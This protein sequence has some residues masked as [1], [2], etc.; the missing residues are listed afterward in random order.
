METTNA[1][2][3]TLLSLFTSSRPSRVLVFHLIF[4]YKLARGFYDKHTHKFSPS[5]MNVL[6]YFGASSIYGSLA[7]FMGVFIRK[8][9]FQPL[10]K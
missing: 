5:C 4:I 2:H 7:E 10:N 1:L 8:A 3:F 9:T 6:S